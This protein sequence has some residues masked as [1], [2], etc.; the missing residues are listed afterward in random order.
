MSVL[1]ERIRADLTSD[2]YYKQNY[3]NDGQRFL[4]WYLKLMCDVMREL[5]AEMRAERL[6]HDP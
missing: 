2:K 3:S 1:L 6:F 4:A 5:N